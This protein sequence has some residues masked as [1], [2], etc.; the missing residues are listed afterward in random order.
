MVKDLS[1]CVVLRVWRKAPHGV[2]ALWPAVAADANGSLCQSFEHIGQ[3]G[4]ADYQGVIRQTRPATLEEASELLAELRQ[5]GYVPV[6]V[7][8]A[9][10]SMIQQRLE[11][12]SA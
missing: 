9:T 7:K 5:R 4:G 6:V 2:I 12:L 10:R 1:E 11:D 8:R 3:H